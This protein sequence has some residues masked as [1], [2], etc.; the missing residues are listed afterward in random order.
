MELHNTTS[1][2]TRK[3]LSSSTSSFIHRKYHNTPF[4]VPMKKPETQLKRIHW[5]S[6]F[7]P[8]TQESPSPTFHT[9]YQITSKIPWRHFNS[10]IIMQNN[11]L[12]HF[13]LTIN[14]NNVTYVK[15]GSF[16]WNLFISCGFLHL[17]VFFT[18]VFLSK[19]LTSG[20]VRS[21]NNELINLNIPF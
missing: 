9:T 14:H 2:P 6:I 10:T 12:P 3:D 15:T 18:C 20:V 8:S 16:L 17:C 21:P 13:P 5:Y 7:P 19:K 1:P 11:Y 4:N